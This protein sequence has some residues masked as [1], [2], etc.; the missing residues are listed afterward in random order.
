MRCIFLLLFLWVHSW[1][2]SFEEE[3]SLPDVRNITFGYGSFSPGVQ[4]VLYKAAYVDSIGNDVSI[5]FTTYSPYYA[6]STIAD[7]NGKWFY[8]MS[9][10]GTLLGVN[11][12]GTL[13]GKQESTSTRYSLSISQ[14]GFDAFKKIKPHHSFKIGGEY[15]YSTLKRYGIFEV[16]GD[17]Y[18][19]VETND[20][21]L[22]MFVGYFFQNRENVFKQKWTYE[23]E[24][25][26]GT[27]VISLHSSVYPTP[28]DIDSDISYDAGF[29]SRN[30]FYFGHL[31]F[32]GFE[33]GG[34]GTHEFYYK[35]NV[36]DIITDEN[37][38]DT[39]SI[40]TMNRFNLGIVALWNF[41]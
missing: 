14:V 40:I 20:A 24:I 37:I 16:I 28:E 41:R 21:S 29:V 22:F 25:S 7:F 5:N 38:I 39:E 12:I 35:K 15:V 33:L 17:Q 31:I 4:T 1:G 8:R 3:F 6:T 9:S 26:L 36:L 34:R 2:F 32:K 19:V 11:T 27:P 18:S 30:S 10:S 13:R 23:V